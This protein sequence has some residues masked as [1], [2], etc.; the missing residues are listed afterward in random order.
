MIGRVDTLVVRVLRR[1]LLSLAVV[2]FS[3]PLPAAAQSVT[4]TILGTVTDASV[5]ASGKLGPVFF[6]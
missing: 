4:G 2:A 1:I 3:A 6:K 5:T